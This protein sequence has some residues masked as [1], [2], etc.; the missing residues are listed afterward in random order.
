[1]YD[2]VWIINSALSAAPG[3]SIY[4]EEERTLQTIETLKSIDQ[5]C[6]NN[7]KFIFDCLDNVDR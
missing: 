7:R 2:G 6:P 5:H 3:L 1:M 4:S